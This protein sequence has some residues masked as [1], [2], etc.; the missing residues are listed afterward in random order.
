VKNKHQLYQNNETVYTFY[1]DFNTINF[2][3]K[4]MKVEG[5]NYVSFPPSFPKTGCEPFIDEK[6]PISDEYKLVEKLKRKF[7]S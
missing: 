7:F 3:Y 4:E 5:Y 2:K 6:L 1:F